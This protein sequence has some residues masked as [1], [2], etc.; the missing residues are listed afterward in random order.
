MAVIEA[1]LGGLFFRTLVRLISL[2]ESMQG[3]SGKTEEQRGLPRAVLK[4]L[5]SHAHVPHH[6]CDNQRKTS[7]SSTTHTGRRSDD[8]DVVPFKNNTHTMRGAAK[9]ADMKHSD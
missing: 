6:R 2:C 1:D 4:V 8:S 3:T 9:T 7:D 5:S